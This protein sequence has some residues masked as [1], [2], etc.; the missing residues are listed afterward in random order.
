MLEVINKIV[1][2]VISH[3]SSES[4]ELINCSKQAISEALLAAYK[5]GQESQKSIVK[6]DVPALLQST[7][8]ISR[9]MRELAG[10][11]HKDNYT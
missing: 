4:V 3:D 11:P 9:R 10:I 1:E 8:S 6:E 2:E 5:A 7:S